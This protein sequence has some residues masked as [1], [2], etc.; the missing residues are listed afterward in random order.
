[1]A[2]AEDK[3]QASAAAYRVL[4]RKYR[5]QSF[6]DLIGQETLIRTLTNAIEAKR[7]AQAYILTGVRGVGKTTTARILAR[8]LNY[9]GP[10]G[11]KG[12]TAGP[13]DDCPICQAIAEDRHVDVIEMDAA[14]R[15]GVGDIRELIEG[16]RYRPVEARYKVYIIDEVHMLSTSAFNA[17]LKTLEEPP[18][19]VVFIFATTEI[20]KVPV[21]VLSRCQRFDL[22]RVSPQLLSE[23]FTR[24][25][26]AEGAEVEP[27]AIGL[28]ARAADGSVRD[29]LS[30]LDQAIALTGGKVAG[31]AVR[32]MLGIAD[33][34]RLYDLLE[35][36]LGGRLEE[37]LAILSDLY[38]LGGDPLVVLQDLME[39]VHGATRLKLSPTAAEDSALPDLERSRGQALGKLGLAELARAWQLLLKGY[40]ETQGAP[41][42][43]QA[44]EMVLIRLA[45]ASTLPPPGDL[46]RQLR[47]EGG[48]AEGGSALPS[49]GGRAQAPVAS[50]P[51]QAA[52]V[53]AARPAPMT[54]PTTSSSAANAAPRASETG[55]GQPARALAPRQSEP[56]PIAEPT[57]PSFSPPGGSLA[58][59]SFPALVALARAQGEQV[60]ANHLECDVALVRFASGHLVLRPLADAPKDLATRLTRLLGEWTGG[61]WRVELSSD[62][63][64]PPLRQQAKAEAAASREAAL[65]HPL[66]QAF[67]TSFP[68]A[69]LVGHRRHE[70]NVLPGGDGDVTPDPDVEL[71]P[72]IE[73]DE[74]EL[75][76][77]DRAAL[78]G[79]SPED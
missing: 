5:P 65:Q 47:R 19:H 69:R 41:L 16:V 21:T 77:E 75:S 50:A 67:L 66:A 64:A 52:P 40:G 11:D 28:I 2:E 18:P 70:P 63:G 68:D 3:A 17:L 29:G 54:G 25:A 15:T 32:Q 42:P 1:M 73:P 6:A 71:D 44:T 38:S 4:A 37:G 9:K 59:A 43:L 24:I 78:A 60:L 23:H 39:I 49:P 12:P 56:E 58:I 74:A 62:E 8:A 61:N 51:Q 14:S 33:R 27:E 35:A 76:D 22:R 10:E 30:L 36:T 53:A 34:G 7:I 31:E 20:R 57:R 26:E 79:F 48:A 55:G 45:H 72:D 13:T 46:I